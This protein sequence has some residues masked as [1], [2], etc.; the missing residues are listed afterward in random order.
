MNNLTPFSNVI[1]EHVNEDKPLLGI[2]LGLQLLFESSE[3]SPN[4]NGLGFFEGESK[5]ANGRK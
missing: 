5:I 3:E 1:K 4:I 2:C